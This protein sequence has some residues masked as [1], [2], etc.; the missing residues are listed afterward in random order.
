MH[1]SSIRLCLLALGAASLLS[2]SVVAQQPPAE[3]PPAPAVPEIADEP[4]AVDPATVVDPLVARKATVR[5]DNSTLRGIVEWLE[6][7]QGLRVSVDQRALEEAG[8][9][10]GEQVSERLDDEPL[11][12]LLDR[13]RTLGVGWYLDEGRLRL[14]T[15]AVADEHMETVSYNIGGLRDDGYEAEDLLAA[16]TDCTGGYWVDLNGEGGELVLL[17]D[18]LFVRQTSAVQR[19][20]R[21]LLAA[22]RRHGRRTWTLDA[23]QHDPLRALLDRRV[24]LALR[25]VPL[26]DAI[27]KLAVDLGADLRLDQAALN[28]QGLRERVPVTVEIEDQPLR[29]VLQAMLERHA[30]TWLV[31][32][33]VLWVVP[34][35]VAVE[36][37]HTA[38]FDVRDLCRDRDESSA[39]QD[40]IERQTAGPWEATG[41]EGTIAFARPGAMVV[42]HTGRQLDG[43]LE[44]LENYRVALHASKPRVKPQV[45]ETHYYLLPTATAEELERLLPQLVAPETWRGP[46]HPEAVGT[47]LKITSSPRLLDRQGRRIANAPQ[48][49]NDA[50]A[51]VV[52]HSVL[53]IR[54]ATD[55]HGEITRLLQRIENGDGV[56]AN[57]PL[58]KGGGGMGGMGGMG[59]GFGGGLF[60]VAPE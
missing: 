13:L 60:S 29:S 28:D 46:E 6:S 44:L 37:L 10:L 49:A 14:T 52:P 41:G 43:V 7:T 2:H 55:T 26:A 17:G 59:G 27:A 21:G 23:P 58:L 38:V 25:D 36:Q 15:N 20:V 54:Q 40:A 57:A 12:L 42:R 18:V 35:A 11:Y 1:V 24:T 19:E 50:D 34:E 32:D 8:I 53:A 39:L 5:L 3:Q 31:R 45:V 56:M 48:A 30:L 22:I 16:I 4:R 33:G 9:L 47:I 51:L